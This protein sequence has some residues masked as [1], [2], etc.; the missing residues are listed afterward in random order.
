MEHEERSKGLAEYVERWDNGVLE[1]MAYSGTMTVKDDWIE[2]IRKPHPELPRY[3]RALIIPLPPD[4]DWSKLSDFNSP[5]Q[6]PHPPNGIIIIECEERWKRKGRKY[7][8]PLTAFLGKPGRTSVKEVV[9]TGGIGNR[10]K[11]WISEERFKSITK[12]NLYVDK[13]YADQIFNRG[14]NN[15]GL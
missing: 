2:R 7:I 15:S 5:K 8:R 9:W 1:V 6:P 12:R 4:F 3:Q 14:K 10:A 11:V 13:F